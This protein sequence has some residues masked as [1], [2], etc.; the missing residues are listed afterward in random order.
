MFPQHGHD[1]LQAQLTILAMIEWTDSLR[2]R[3]KK[4]LV[5]VLTIQSVVSGVHAIALTAGVLNINSV[6]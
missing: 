1:Q 3:P 2:K 5:R 6:P 4:N